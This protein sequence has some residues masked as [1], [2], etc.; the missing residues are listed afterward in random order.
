M[1]GYEKINVRDKTL[2]KAERA[3]SLW[4]ENMNHMVD[5]W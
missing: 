5:E 3:L 4:I 2:A 1:I